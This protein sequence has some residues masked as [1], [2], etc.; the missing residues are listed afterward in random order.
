[1]PR[2]FIA[3]WYHR[4][5]RLDRILQAI[6]PRLQRQLQ[7]DFL[8]RSGFPPPAVPSRG[9]WILV[10]HR[11]AGKSRLLPLFAEL[12]GLPGVD[13]DTELARQSGRSLRDWVKEDEPGFRQAERALFLSRPEQEVDA[14]GGGFLS[15]HADLLVGHRA[16]LVP[17]SFESYRERLLADR[18]RPR[19]R[20][21][22][23]LEE[24]IAAVFEERERTHARVPTLSLVVA[25]LALG[26]KEH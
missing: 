1:M 14:A 25:L 3:K 24:E 13:L 5:V 6:D 7:S 22:L 18:E 23:S 20:P 16:V 15:L 26:V 9:R 10:G 8:A 11:A 19:L 12:T 2:H 21:A 17:I 4:P